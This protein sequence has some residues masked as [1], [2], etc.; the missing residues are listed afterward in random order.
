MQG[1][2]IFRIS[3]F[4]PQAVFARAEARA[5]ERSDPQ[6]DSGGYTQYHVSLMQNGASSDKTHPS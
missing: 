5:H 1:R 2:L 3:E 4:H 6:C